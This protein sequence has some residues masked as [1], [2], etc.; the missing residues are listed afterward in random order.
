MSPLVTLYPA[1]DMHQLS[2]PATQNGR[3]ARDYLLPMGQRGVQTYIQN[4]DT[5]LQVAFVDNIV[6]PVT[7]THSHPDSSYVCSPFNHYF[8]YGLE[9]LDKLGNPTLENALRL[10]LRPVIAAY[11]RS[12]FDRVVYVNN[13]LLSTNLYPQLSPDQVRSVVNFLVDRY[14]NRPIIFRSVDTTG[15]PG[16]Y[17]TLSQMGCRMVFSRQVYYQTPT[18]PA[19]W[20]KKQLKEDTRHLR[21]SPYKLVEQLTEAD[22]PR[23]TRLYQQLYLEKYSLFNPQFT[24]EFFRLAL[25]SDAF[26]LR[27]YQKS[28]DID[29]VLGYY[30][31]NGIMT[32]P[33]FGYDINLPQSLS[34]YRL[35]SMQV[36]QEGRDRKLLINASAGAGQFKRLRGG[37]ATLEY[38]AVFDHHLPARQKWPWA[39]LKLLLDTIAVPI[40]Q[41][42]GY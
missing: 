22:I 7:L 23:L 6:L 27:A 19:L 25:N 5:E 26:V 13:W 4:V 36:L 8:V 28:G 32:Q 39:F 2:W 17:K 37:Q 33:I 31:I 35:L 11:R 10:L 14:P 18:D 9:E 15:Q 20:R 3:L 29:A 1:A 34:L 16:I 21:R 24:P 41:K 30:W 12:A 40:I 38:N 42:N